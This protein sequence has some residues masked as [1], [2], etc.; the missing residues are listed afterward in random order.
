MTRRE[1]WAAIRARSD[2]SATALEF[3]GE[4]LSWT[5]LALR[6]DRSAERLAALGIGPG[7]TL[8]AALPSTPAFV[9]LLH[10]LYSLGATLLPLHARLTER[11]LLH[12]LRDGRADLLLF[13]S[14]EAGAHAAS[15]AGQSEIP[16]IALGEFAC[17]GLAHGVARLARVP[18]VGEANDAPLALLYTSGTSGTPKGAE[19][20]AASFAA[21]AAAAA[22][23]LGTR[24]G[25][26]WLC[27]LPL[28]HVG[29]LSLPIRAALQGGSIVL[30]ERF[31]PERVSTA[32]D[33]ESIAGISLVPAMLARLLEVRGDTPPPTSLGCVL[34]G[35]SGA[36]AAL[37]ERAQA[38][39]WPL[40]P[41]YGLTEACSQVATR[42][43]EDRASALGGGLE[44]LPGTEVAIRAEDGGELGRDEPGE[45]LVR[46]AALMRG[47]RG[48]PDDTA[49][50]LAGGW[51][52][53]GDIGRID[54][55]GSLHVLDRRSDLIVSGGEN[56]YP[57]EIEAALSEHPFV[58]EAGVAALPDARFGARPGAWIALRPE[59]RARAPR[60]VA[61][62]LSDHCRARLAGYKQPIA[63]HFAE[64][65]PRNVT[66]KLLRRALRTLDAE[67]ISVH[68][69]H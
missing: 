31:D 14:D 8:A 64:A 30:H 55:R 53:T 51:L 69:E 62:I 21:S 56:L 26:R 2:P 42:R 10:A 3:Q 52:H 15:A 40:A 68:A 32:L 5:E 65:L 63:Y 50:A 7:S 25:E 18:Q 17:G 24:P 67:A 59:A 9:E 57:A 16:A 48:R 20:S 35:G 4:C 61:R 27:C 54:A 44:P 58:L 33:R 60:E 6:A 12:P 47:Y 38:C 45:I 66:G 41:T 36:P 28:Y 43:P 23:H 13:G 49:R 22:K 34:L 46:S 39:G 19:L 37:L 29:G 11:E 1:S